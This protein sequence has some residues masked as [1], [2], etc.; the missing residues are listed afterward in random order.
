MIIKLKLGC[1]NK[2][3]IIEK[4]TNDGFLY[5]IPENKGSIDNTNCNNY[6]G[7]FIQSLY[8]IDFTKP[9]F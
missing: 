2:F 6:R 8:I 9:T 3:Q 1:N 7:V 4:A 5:Y